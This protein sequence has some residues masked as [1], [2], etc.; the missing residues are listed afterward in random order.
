VVFV[1][2]LAVGFVDRLCAEGRAL[3]SGLSSSLSGGC[4]LFSVLLPAIPNGASQDANLERQFLD[5]K[6]TRKGQ[7]LVFML[8][9]HCLQPTPQPHSLSCIGQ[10]A[11]DL[12]ADASTHDSLSAANC[13]HLIL[14]TDR[15]FS[16]SNRGCI[17]SGCDEHPECGAHTRFDTRP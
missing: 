6:P 11:C 8:P 2:L 9:R 3:R 17:L 5:H 15:S 14:V 16:P 1:A 10:L 7:R 13:R 12:A 4:P